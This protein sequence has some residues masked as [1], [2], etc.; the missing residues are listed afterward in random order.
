MDRVDIDV[1]ESAQLRHSNVRKYAP[2][3]WRHALRRKWV[4]RGVGCLGDGVYIDRNV[5]LMRHPEHISLGSKVMLKEGTRICPANP[6]ATIS[7]GDWTTIGYHCFIFATSR[8]EIGSNCLIA[9]FCYLVDSDHGIAR[10]QLIRE[11]PMRY[12]PIRIGSDVW[13]GAGVTVT[14]GVTIGDG[15]VIGARSVVTADIPPDSI[16]V[17]APARIIGARQ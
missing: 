8:I 10:G 6:T 11:Q 17:G 13:L 3:T 14:A 16:A 5:E 15:A 7:I 2:F 1:V 12:E 9:P 4:T